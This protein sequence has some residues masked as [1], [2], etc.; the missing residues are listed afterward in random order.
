MEITNDLKA[1]EEVRAY[2]KRGY[3]Y[4]QLKAKLKISDEEISK[5]CEKHPDFKNELIKRYGIDKKPI[6]IKEIKPKATKKAD[7]TL[8]GK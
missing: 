6:E 8:E 2:I 5:L 3:G 4:E 7:S 1:I